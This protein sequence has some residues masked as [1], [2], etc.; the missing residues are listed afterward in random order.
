MR[1]EFTFLSMINMVSGK[2]HDYF[3]E[4]N[5]RYVFLVPNNVIISDKSYLVR[6]VILICENAARSDK[7]NIYELLSDM[8]GITPEKIEELV[9]N[10]RDYNRDMND[11]I[12]HLNMGLYEHLRPLVG[13]EV[14][15][16]FV[17]SIADNYCDTFVSNLYHEMGVSDIRSRIFEGLE[18]DDFDED[19][20]ICYDEPDP[21]L[22]VPDFEPD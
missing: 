16:E 5:E 9:K 22:T 19:T 13:V 15:P 1:E 17:S 2:V 18:Y 4:F 8:C 12:N 10:T 14:E 3:K 11:F 6:M 21:S 20:A 7:D